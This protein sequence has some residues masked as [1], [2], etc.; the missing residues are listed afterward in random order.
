M[1]YLTAAFLVLLNSCK[2]EKTLTPKEQPEQKTATYLLFASRDYST[3]PSQ[4]TTAEVRLQ[5]QVINYR[6]GEQKIV[7]DSI[8]PVRLLKD[9]PLEAQKISVLKTYP[10]LN[11]HQKLNAGISVI[12]RDGQLIYQEAKS[13]EA[14]PGTS[15][16]Q[17]SAAL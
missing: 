1:I 13:D 11:S 7:W 2:K 10:V 14:G 15:N 5:L 3:T 12:Y 16:I 8:L 4:N 17:L 6:T 9:F